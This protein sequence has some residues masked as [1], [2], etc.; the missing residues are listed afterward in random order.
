MAIGSAGLAHYLAREDGHEEAKLLETHLMALERSLGPFFRAVHACMRM[1]RCS[2]TLSFGLRL[3]VPMPPVAR[4]EGRLA[5]AE[6]RSREGQP[7]F[8]L[9]ELRSVLMDVLEGGVEE[10]NALQTLTE[11]AATGEGGESA[12]SFES[13]SQ[14]SAPG[15]CRTP[16]VLVDLVGKEKQVVADLHRF[17]ADL[18]A[19]INGVTTGPEV[20]GLW[21]NSELQEV[22]EGVSKLAKFFEAAC[23]R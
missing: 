14:T 18:A 2:Q 20:W 4:M 6:L 10:V 15:N 21:W 1:I 12:G 16:Q 13:K 11:R 7:E 5:A 22:S 8:A 23:D 19:K 17:I 9:K 3:S